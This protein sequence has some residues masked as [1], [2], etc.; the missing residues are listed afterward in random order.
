M[1]W[2]VIGLACGLGACSP[3]RMAQAVRTLESQGSAAYRAGPV[4]PAPPEAPR[5][6]WLGQI[7]G[8]EDLGWRSPLWRRLLDGLFGRAPGSVLVRPTG[9][10]VDEHL[11]AVADPGAQAL[12]IFDFERRRLRGVQRAGPQRL[13]SPVAVAL[14]PRR[15]LWVADSY[16]ASL[17]IFDARG[18]WVRTITSAQLRRPVGLAFDRQRERLYV[19]DSQAH[20][21]WV[22]TADGELL[23][24]VGRRGTAPGEF[25][26]PTHVTV[27]EAGVLYVVDALGF[28]VQMLTPQG[29][30]VGQFGRHGDASGDFARPKGIAVDGRG[31]IYVVDAL[32]DA[33]QLFTRQGQLL[34]TFG[35]RGTNA[36]EF[37]LPHGICLGSDRKIYVADAYNHRIQIFES[38]GDD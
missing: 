34:L 19:A 11:M 26:F 20:C 30:A 24:A 1:R 4:W 32:F 13:V 17:M 23:T 16:A 10:A 5:I 35:R 21:L 33:V 28:Q 3:G 37:W 7:Q 29:A 15:T 14:G 9:I 36:G 6:H 25:N 27:D 2:W 18:R 8:P 31:H 22:F 12:W 38:V